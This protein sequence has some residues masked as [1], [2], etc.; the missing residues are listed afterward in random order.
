M[1]GENFINWS[2][3]KGDTYKQTCVIL[4]K[5]LD[6]LEKWQSISG[7]TKN[8][9]Y[10]ALTRAETNVYIIKDTDYKKW[11]KEQ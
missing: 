10:V 7:K 5:N 3:S 2:Y 9:L 6:Q 11:K 4:T 8:G 1:N